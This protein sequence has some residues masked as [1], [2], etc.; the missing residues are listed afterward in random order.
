LKRL[1][2]LILEELNVKELRYDSI[3][4]VAAL[5]GKG[6]V[7][8]SEASNNSAI[9]TDI[10]PELAAEGMAREIVHRVQTMRRSAGFEIADNI[11][12]YYQGDDY[13]REVMANK[14]LADYIKQETL[15]REL[16]AGVPEEVDFKETYK[17]DGHEVSLGVKRLK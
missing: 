5:D 11:V 10:T 1:E 2:P 17:L 6:Y 12:I 15:S 13:I 3:E 8:V 7:V 9:S 16:I 14:T 4:N